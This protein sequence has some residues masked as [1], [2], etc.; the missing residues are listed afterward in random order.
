MT[1]GCVIH[2]LTFI[3]NTMTMT[4]IFL[5]RVLVPVRGAEAENWR[6]EALGAVGVPVPPVLAGW[7]PSL[8]SGTAAGVDGG[9]GGVESVRGGLAMTMSP[10]LGNFLHKRGTVVGGNRGGKRLR[11]GNRLVDRLRR[12]AGVKGGCHE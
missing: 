8:G 6:G 3:T 4:Y 5:V 11:L 7:E 10:D 12:W 1:N 9:A 2:C